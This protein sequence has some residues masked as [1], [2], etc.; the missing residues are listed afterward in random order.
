MHVLRMGIVVLIAGSLGL[1]SAKA[2]TFTGNAAAQKA[3]TGR[4]TLDTL[5][6]QAAGLAPPLNSFLVSYKGKLLVEEYYNGLGSGEVVNLK[7]ASKSIL[8]ALVGIAFAEGHL[9][10]LQQRLVDLF[11]SYI[12]AAPDP[13]KQMVTLQHLL[14]MRACLETTSFHNYGKWV[15]SSDWVRAAI[16]QPMVCRPG[17]SMVYSTGNSHI[18]SAV[19]TEAAGM[20]TKRFAR[21]YLFEPLGINR[22]VWDRSPEGYYFGGN[23]LALSPRDLLK[24]GQLYLQRGEYQ[25]KRVLPAGWIYRSWGRYAHSSYSHHDHGY[26]WWIDEYAGHTVYFAW[27]YGGQYLFVVPSLDVVVVCTSDLTG[28]DTKDGHNEDILRLLEETILPAFEAVQ[29]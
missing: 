14:S 23:N 22:V 29:P 7:S 16:Q 26:F 4:T 2:Q 5:R 21:Q 3:S 28:Q 9:D 1:V 12:D 13:R 24:V 6:T 8:S 25:G 11:P 15:A 10:S 18:M 27:G 20:S 17:S 19:L